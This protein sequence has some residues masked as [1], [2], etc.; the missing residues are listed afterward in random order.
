MATSD[1]AKFASKFGA[2]PAPVVASTYSTPALATTFPVTQSSQPA[3]PGG[4]FS[5]LS[6][7]FNERLPLFSASASAAATPAPAV[8]GV[9]PQPA[10]VVT[11][12]SSSV[13]SSVSEW[14]NPAQAPA[15]DPT[16][17]SH[18]GSFFNLT[19]Q[20]RIIG[21]LMSFTTAVLFLSFTF[22]YLPQI[23]VGASAKFAISYAM[24]NVCFLL[25]SFFLV[26]PYKQVTNMFGEGRW[27]ASLVYLIT[28][29]GTLY[30]A[31]AIRSFYVVIPMLVIQVL[32]LLYYLMTY[33]PSGVA[34]TMIIK[35]IKGMATGC[36]RTTRA[37][38]PI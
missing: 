13:F 4:Y 6:N 14:W 24:T 36:F 11:S 25:S 37:I 35:V 16:I 27:I 38:L 33:L 9:V 18:F 29:V 22:L 3:A 23:I 32:A 17:L 10:P 7:K 19:W 21:F 1:L 26:G 34:N 2:Q 31:Y 20:Q 8:N 15:N 12:T 30:S 28:L 5:T